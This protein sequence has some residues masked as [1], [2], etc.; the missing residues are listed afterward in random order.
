MLWIYILPSFFL[1]M[2]ASVLFIWPDVMS[3]NKRLTLLLRRAKV[4]IAGCHKYPI[5]S[6]DCDCRPC[7]ISREL[8]NAA[9]MLERR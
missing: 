3:E 6:S 9:N 1:G 5:L 7:E 8:E 4:N 2:L